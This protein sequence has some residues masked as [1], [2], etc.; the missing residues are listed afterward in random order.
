MSLD[1]KSF[2]VFCK[3]ELPLEVNEKIGRHDECPQCKRSLRCCKMCGFYDRH[4][5]NECK[6]PNAERIIEKERA[7][8][9]S[10]FTISN[11][12]TNNSKSS[13][14]L[15]SAANALFKF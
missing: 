2:C 11:G 9:C 15:L 8:F 14:D 4:A 1:K 13:N 12:T 6:E 10:Y 7:N 5:Y 3:V